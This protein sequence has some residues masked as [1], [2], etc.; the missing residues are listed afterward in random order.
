MKYTYFILCALV[1]VSACKQKSD[2]EKLKDLLK[3]QR[4]LNKQVADLQ[5]K[6]GVKKAKAAP[7]PVYTEEI[8]PRDFSKYITVQAKVHADNNVIA[9]PQATG[10]VK[11]VY[12]T[13]GRYVKK[14]QVLGTLDDNVISTQIAEANQQ[15]SFLKDIYLKQKE[16]WDQNIGTEVQLL[17]AKNNYESAVKRKRTAETQRSLYRIVAPISGVV[18]A[19]D[20]RVGEIASPG[21]PRGIHIVNDQD[22][23]VVANVGEGNISLVDQGDR[24]LVIIPDLRDTFS[25]RI[26]YV[27]KTIDPTSRSFQVEVNLPR[28]SRFK[29]N[30]IAEL[31]IAA[32]SKPHAITVPSGLVKHTPAG[33]VV[34]V[35]EDGKVKNRIVKVGMVYNGRTEILDGLNLDDR[36]ITSGG[37]N[38]SEGET[39][40]VIQP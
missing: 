16:L 8:T 29:P 26:S 5:K 14:G 1:L 40:E 15:I 34:S 3:E 17:T 28:S 30:M 11:K 4:D 19:V 7:I 37:E 31:K 9:T 6:I 38:L 2:Q 23:K 33:D 12:V 32:Y 22:L 21:S 20:I 35:V 25:G 24:V 18:D 36:V 39:I 10:V 13:N 27:G